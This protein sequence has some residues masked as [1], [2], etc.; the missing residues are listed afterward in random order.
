MIDFTKGPHLMGVINVT[1]NSFSDGGDFIDP[2]DAIRQGLKMVEQGAVI[3]DIGGE[4]TKPGEKPIS[5]DEEQ[6]RILPVIKGLKAAGVQAL[7]AVDTRNAQTMQTAIDNGANIIND[8]SALTHDSQSLNVVAKAQIPVILMHMKGTPETMQIAPHYEDVVREVY[9]FLEG[10]V[11]ACLKSGILRHNI[12]VDPG[13][14]FGKR[15]E[16]NINLLK[17]MDKFHNLG[18]A[19]LL[20]ASRKSFIEK[21]YPNTPPK[22]R[23]AGSLVAAVEG[24]KQGVQIFRV[25]DVSETAQAFAVHN[26]IMKNN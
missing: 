4:S 23:L 24:L 13:I 22:Q 1:P 12:I 16:D 19:V 7:I 26:K 21:I 10:R 6:N 8:I 14:G 9:K 15:L 11:E 18:C 25:H 2:E 3:L 20:G 5:Q 17:N